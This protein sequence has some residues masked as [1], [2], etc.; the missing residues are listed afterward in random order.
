[1]VLVFRLH[2]AAKRFKDESEGQRAKRIEIGR[3]R[4]TT[5]II[6]AISDFPAALK[7]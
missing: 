7:I 6:I 2:P 1:M 4:K 5:G 3:I